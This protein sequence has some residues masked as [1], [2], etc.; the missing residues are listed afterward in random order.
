MGAS[1][2]AAIT[3]ANVGEPFAIVLDGKVLTLQLHLNDLS[4]SYT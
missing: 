4:E 2:F 1:E 3:Q